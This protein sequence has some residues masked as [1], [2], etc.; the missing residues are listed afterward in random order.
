M[1]ICYVAMRGCR[2]DVVGAVEKEGQKCWEAIRSGA[3]LDD[4][5]LITRFSLITFSDLK[6]FHFYYWF[7]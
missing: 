2:Y 5:S 6:K 7:A 1:V 3:A 4:L